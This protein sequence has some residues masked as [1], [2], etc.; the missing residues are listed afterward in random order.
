MILLHLVMLLAAVSPEAQLRTALQ[1]KTGSVTLPSGVIEISR[2]IILPADAHDLDI[3]GASTTLKAAATFRG[4]AL[5]AISGGKNIH[6]HNLSLDGNRDAISRPTA[7]PSSD[8][9]LSRVVPNNGI[10]AENVSS[11]E[12]GDVKATGIGGFTVLVSASHTVKIHGVEISN[13]GGLNARNRNNG[14]GGIVVEE[15]TTDFEI[16]RCQIGN[17]RGNG[18]GT[19]SL[20][21]SPRNERGRIADNEF[22]MIGRDAIQLAAATGVT[23]ENNRGRMIGYPVEDV[24]VEAHAV[25]A[26]VAAFAN[27]DRAQVRGNQFEEVN[28]RCLD[29][30]G[31]HDSEVGNNTCLNEDAAVNYPY[32]DFAIIL[33][34]TNVRLT[35]NTINGGL[36]G[37]VIVGGTGHTISGNH[38]VHLNMAR[39]DNSGP[40][41]CTTAG[42]YLEGKG[43]TIERNEIS[44]FGMSLHCIGG[45]SGITRGMNT[46]SRN[47]CS[48]EA[49]VA[50]LAPVPAWPDW[51]A[52]F[53]PLH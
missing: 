47:E 6:L 48:D 34:N 13:S 52:R 43:N 20:P 53:A 40:P 1:A 30:A 26:T 24:D 46:I 32:G 11:L 23:A 33:A 19:R 28:G 45:A 5:I 42:I 9:I 16:T 35:D 27:V 8:A 41:H 25:P 15:G 50:Q 21:G 22:T 10:L 38:F 4:R 2:E 17:V 39:C 14:T 37:A 44:G 31:L 29:L 49:Q 18:I 51:H 12:I 7:L 3:K 36:V